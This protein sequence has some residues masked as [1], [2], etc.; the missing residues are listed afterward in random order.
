MPGFRG[1][2]RHAGALPAPI[3]RTSSAAVLT[4]TCMALGA[5]A[6]QAG[7]LYL[8]EFATPS[9][10][11]AGAGAQAWA[12]DAA[13]AWHNAA[14][15]T[16][17]EGNEVTFGAGIGSVDVEFEADPTTPFGGGNGGDA[18]D[19]VPLLG[20]YGV[21]SASDDLKFGVGIFSVSGAALEYD[22]SWTGR[23]QAQEVEILTVSVNP[24]VAYRVTDWLSVSAGPMVTYGK[25][26]FTLAVPPGGAGQ[27]ILDG[28]DVAYGFTLGT[29]FEISPRTRVG[30]GYLS[31]QTLEFDGDLRINPI[32]LNIGSDTELTLAQMVRA[33]VYH[34]ID[35]QW[36][37]L[38][39]VGW[40]DWSELD[41]LLVTTD[42]GTGA[43]PR[44]WEDTYH[45]GI[46]VHYRPEEDW[47]LQAGFAYDS[48][49]VDSVDRTADMAVDKQLRFAVGAQ[50]QLSETLTFGGALEYVDFGDSRIDNS[51]TLV[52]EYDTNRAVFLAANLNWK[53]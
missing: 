40:E 36:A 22:F 7:G 25:L 47:L 32:G 49:P 33:G 16:R 28:D 41:N 21:Y 19:L 9:M 38:G 2:R 4:I 14:G 23:F 48:S 34:E 17:I 43:I 13:T 35:D 18:G 24:T 3:V 37:V 52:G 53:F 31:E 29:L 45:V 42:G 1:A 39:T 46:G 20:T 6:A 11:T 27:A 26:D 8:N 30:I 15:M 10:G 12:N 5:G 51:T 50:Y 44:N